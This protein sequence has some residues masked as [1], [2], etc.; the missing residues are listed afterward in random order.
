[1]KKL[2]TVVSC[3]LA[4]YAVQAEQVNLN[5]LNKQLNIMEN[6]IKSSVS[7]ERTATE[8]RMPVRISSIESTYLQ[9][10]GV[11]FTVRSSI[12]RGHW[13]EHFPAAPM[14]PM[15][16]V[17]SEHDINQ[18]EIATSINGDDIEETIAEA[19]E[20]AAHAYE[21][22]YAQHYSESFA[23]SSR[24]GER[25]LF[26]DLRDEQRD[27]AYEL[28]DLERETRDLNY[29]IKRAEKSQRKTLEQQAQKLAKEK[30]ALKQNQAALLKRANA[31]TQKQALQKEKHEQQRKAYYRQL[32]QTV[33][34]TLCLYGNALKQLPKDERVSFILKSSGDK[35]KHH[36]KD[37]V[38]V[39]TK[40][41][42]NKCAVDDIDTQALL[43][44]S[45]N[46]QF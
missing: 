28:R 15:P 26:R 37:T 35:V 27:V 43:K 21:E 29:Q 19:M 22:G 12:N 38:Y 11:L 25:E 9:G 24:S 1:M 3:L 2:I 10:Q 44:T 13:G 4:S 16:P 46:Y 23:H 41:N 34:E 31:L 17:L 42:I 6:I 5:K 30:K 20:S 36:Y 45:N 8:P 40:Q 7:S 39:F 32:S 33:A 14:P 18:I